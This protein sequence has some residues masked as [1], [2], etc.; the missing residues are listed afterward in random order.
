MK[1]KTRLDQINEAALSEYPTYEVLDSRIGFRAG[2]LWADRNPR[3]Q[4]RTIWRKLSQ[5]PL[6]DYNILCDDCKGIIWQVRRDHIIEH[7]G[8]DWH[9]YIGYHNVKRWAYVRE[10]LGIPKKDTP[11]WID[12]R[13][14]KPKVDE[15]VI[16]L[17]ATDAPGYYKISFG[18]IVDKQT[19]KD[20]DG[21]NIPGVRYWMACPTLPTENNCQK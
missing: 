7:Y 4:H 21:W 19:C 13:K 17:L 12:A 6:G 5:I 11:T 8:D 15:E 16:V 1:D 9:L 14:R 18:H 20:Y 3:I 10:V 2:A